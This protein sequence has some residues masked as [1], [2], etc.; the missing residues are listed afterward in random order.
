MK[1]W[2]P[3]DERAIANKKNPGQRLRAA[4]T[5]FDC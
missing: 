3:A 4:G 1:H 2:R 5:V